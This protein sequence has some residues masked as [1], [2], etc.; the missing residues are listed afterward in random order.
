[1]SDTVDEPI[2]I[3]AAGAR[4][5]TEDDLPG[6]EKEDDGSI[7]LS[8]SD[9]LWSYREEHK[10]QNVQVKQSDCNLPIADD[11]TLAKAFRLST[12]PHSEMFWLSPE[13]TEALE[14]YNQIIQAAYDGKVI[15]VDEQKQYDQ[16]KGKFMVWLRYDEV[17][18]ELHP[19]FEFI[20]E[21]RK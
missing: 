5:L 1:M 18:W 14:K 20:R 8:N 17:G 4:L 16:S 7:K 2:C 6:R 13:D 19:R 11:E 9:A 15:I 10:I 12:V 3:S 21:E